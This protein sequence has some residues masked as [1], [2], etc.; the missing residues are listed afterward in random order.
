MLKECGASTITPGCDRIYF[1]FDVTT[2]SVVAE[3]IR[4]VE[5]VMNPRVFERRS[6]I[7]RQK[8]HALG[9]FIV[10]C[11]VTHHDQDRCISI[12]VC[13]VTE[14]TGNNSMVYT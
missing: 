14:T 1:Q 6:L 5:G 13:K 8:S 12:A 3:A 4:Q 7:F 2:G 9:T 11:P 10:S